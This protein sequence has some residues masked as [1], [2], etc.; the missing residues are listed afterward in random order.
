MGKF[1]ELRVWQRV[2]NLAVYVYR[3]TDEGKFSKDFGLRDQFRRASVSIPSNI[4]EGDELDTDK[5]SIRHF[6]IAK[7]SVAEV[8][9]Q[10]IIAKEIGYIDSEIYNFIEN[11]E[12]VQ[13]S[14]SGS[15][16]YPW[17]LRHTP[18]FMLTP[19]ALILE[20]CAM[21]RVPEF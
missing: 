11:E 10:A 9:T 4:A 16:S 13:Y 7:G 8:W 3:Q 18:V 21:R 17:A 6:Y 14:V 19:F 5:Q 2:K 1:Q 15:C 20:P 12:R